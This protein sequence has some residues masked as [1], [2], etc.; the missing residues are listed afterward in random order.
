MPAPV[1]HTCNPSYSV[2]QRLGGPQLKASPGFFGKKNH[3]RTG[4]VAQSVGPEFKP[5]YYKNK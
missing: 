4:R 3:K 1:A 5:Q 2:R